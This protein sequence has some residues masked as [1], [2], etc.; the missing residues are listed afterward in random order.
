MSLHVTAVTGIYIYT[1]VRTCAH[2]RSRLLYESCLSPGDVVTGLSLKTF[3]SADRFR[4]TGAAERQIPLPPLFQR[5]ADA[6]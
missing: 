3:P 4:V 2:A 5:V 6:P 1:H